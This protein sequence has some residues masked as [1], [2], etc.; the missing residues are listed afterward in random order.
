MNDAI[1]PADLDRWFSPDCQKRYIEQLQ[2]QRRLTGRQAKYFVRL[3]AYLLLKQMGQP[4]EPLTRL[5][6]LHGVVSCT[7]R[8]AADLFYAH[9]ER[10]SDRAAGM[11]LD[12]LGKAGLLEKTFDGNGTV[13]Q[14]W[15]PPALTNSSGL[16]NSNVIRLE[17]DDF[18]PRTDTVLVSQFLV[19]NYN[20]V[21]SSLDE[22]A[23]DISEVLRDWAQRYPKG[24][25]VL[26]RS[27]NHQPVG[28]YVMFPVASCSRRRFAQPPLMSLYL[29]T[30]RTTDPFTLAVPGDPDCLSIFVRSWLIDVPYRNHD[31]LIQ[32][33]QDTQATLRKMREDFPNLC[34]IYAM[35]IHPSYE[36]LGRALGF[37]VTIRDPQSF[38]CW[39]YLPFDRLLEMDVAAAI[40]NNLGPEALK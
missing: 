6:P 23:F 33:L 14:L 19:R 34:D 17:T 2:Q 22:V 16:E 5:K 13:L 26:R 25:R 3:W 18:N 7:H 39:T 38:I 21:V 31:T 8:E 32:L 30:P 9:A 1:D 37:Q 36:A 35:T 10:G 27:D 24:M 12:K 20:F 40:R 29:S 15:T 28:F 4:P 11:I